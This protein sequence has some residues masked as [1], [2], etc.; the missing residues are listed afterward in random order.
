MVNAAAEDLDFG[1]ERF[2]TVFTSPP[3]F[4]SERPTTDENQSWV[5]YKNLDA[6]TNSFLLKVI[7]KSWHSLKPNGFLAINLADVYSEGKTNKICDR[8]NDFI[9][10]LPNA[11][12]VSGLGLRI[13]N[14]PNKAKIKGKINAEVI[15]VFR[16]QRK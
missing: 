12:Y 14:R 5:R 16:K 10:N 13:H 6:W 7:E 11:E 3:F 9:A 15:W 2:D 1:K 8:T 4:R